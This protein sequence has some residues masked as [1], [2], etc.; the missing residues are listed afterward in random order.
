MET[1]LNIF[2]KT[3]FFKDIE[4]IGAVAIFEKIDIYVDLNWVYFKF[5]HLGN[6]SLIFTMNNDYYI[7]YCNIHYIKV[8]V[9][10][11]LI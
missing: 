10:D 3:F 1:S 7:F 11:I 2:G 6:Y 5:G 9:N 8:A 4:F